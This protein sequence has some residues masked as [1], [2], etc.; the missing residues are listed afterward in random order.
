MALIPEGSRGRALPGDGRD[1]LDGRGDLGH[2]LPAR[3]AGA[4]VNL[5]RWI[6]ETSSRTQARVAHQVVVGVPAD[7]AE[8]LEVRRAGPLALRPA[9]AR[10]AAA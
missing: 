7:P 8:P 1:A 9:V 3:E 5:A 6:I 2:Q 10:R 4:P